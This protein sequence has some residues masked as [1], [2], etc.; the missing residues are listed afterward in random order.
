ML[1][2]ILKTIYWKTLFSTIFPKL[3][4]FLLLSDISTESLRR[5]GYG[6]DKFMRLLSNYPNGKLNLHAWWQRG[7]LTKQHNISIVYNSH[8]TYARRFY[9][10]NNQRFWFRM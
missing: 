4:L 3:F 10:H 6:D 9:L 5:I 2:P 1:Q 7:M 8:G